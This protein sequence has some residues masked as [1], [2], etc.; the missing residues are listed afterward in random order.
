[1][2]GR[3]VESS[4]TVCKSAFISITEDILTLINADFEHLLD[5]GRC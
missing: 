5:F 2:T 3:G 1:M 4:E